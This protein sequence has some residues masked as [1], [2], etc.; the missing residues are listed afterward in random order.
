MTKWEY[1]KVVAWKDRMYSVNDQ[2]L[3][4]W[5]KPFDDRKWR[6]PLMLRYLN[7]L[8]Q[9]G[10]ELVSALGESVGSQTLILKRPCA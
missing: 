9:E 7:E 5:G 8:G 3:Q 4:E 2:C 10:W 6:S 1:T